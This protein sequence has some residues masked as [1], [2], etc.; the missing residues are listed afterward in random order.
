MSMADALP[1]LFVSDVGVPEGE[2]D[3][4]VASALPS[5][6][7]IACEKLSGVVNAT[8]PFLTRSVICAGF[9]FT[10]RLPP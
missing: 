8:C 6:M 1:G 5:I 3:D 7:G 4:P 9:V 10:T 2:A